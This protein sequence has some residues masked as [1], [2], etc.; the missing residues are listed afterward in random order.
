MELSYLYETEISKN[1]FVVSAILS[2][3][4]SWSKRTRDVLGRSFWLLIEIILQQTEYSP[5]LNLRS[6]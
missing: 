4:V 3:F 2:K 1:R 5:T 6:G